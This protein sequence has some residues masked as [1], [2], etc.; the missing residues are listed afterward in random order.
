MV[1]L[2]KQP[3]GKVN[4]YEYKVKNIYDDNFALDFRTVVSI[5]K[6]LKF[7]KFE[8]EN[9]FGYEEEIDDIYLFEESEFYRYIESLEAGVYDELHYERLR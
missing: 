1:N 9:Q 3:Q 2:L 5:D 8:S 6:K 7:D 4:S